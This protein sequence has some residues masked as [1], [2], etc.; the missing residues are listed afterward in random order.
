M[1]HD[2]AN[3]PLHILRARLGGKLTLT[4]WAGAWRCNGAS[5]DSLVETIAHALKENACSPRWASA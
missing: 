4:Y 2:I 1:D 3:Q 5:G